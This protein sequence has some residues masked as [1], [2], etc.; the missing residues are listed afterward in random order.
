MATDSTLVKGAYDANKGYDIDKTGVSKAINKGAKGLSKAVEKRKKEEKA[1]EKADKLLSTEAADK[2]RKNTEAVEDTSEQEHR[3]YKRRAADES[4]A[5]RLATAIEMYGQEDSVL[6]SDRKD[7]TLAL[8]TKKGWEAAED[9]PGIDSHF[10]NMREILEQQKKDI[11]PSKL[12]ETG[13]KV[14]CWSAR[15]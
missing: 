14:V 9:N 15:V 8:E 6:D 3:Q 12:K 11:E 1:K 2:A 7:K 5:D 4:H 10:D 13:V